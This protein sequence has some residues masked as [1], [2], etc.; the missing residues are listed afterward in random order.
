M[1]DVKV[2]DV[3]REKPRTVL[4]SG[5]PAPVYRAAPFR[6]VHTEGALEGGYKEVE[7]LDGTRRRLKL[8]AA[9]ER[10]PLWPSEHRQYKDA[11]GYEVKP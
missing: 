4:I 2:G 3:R 10:C 6:V 11:R 7:A 5:E 1:A 9:V 8:A